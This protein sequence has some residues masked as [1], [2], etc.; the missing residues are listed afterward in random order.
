VTQCWGTLAALKPQQ[1]LEGPGLR[2]LLCSQDF[3]EWEA[4]LA[5]SLGHHRSRLLP[6][7]LPF[8]AQIRAGGVDEFQVLWLQGTG[9]LEL[10]REQCGHGVLWLP[11]QGLSHETINGEEQLS[12]PGMG[13]LFR[14][15]DV[16]RGLTTESLSGVSIVVPAQHLDGLVGAAPL[17]RQGP[18]ARQLIEAGWQLAA[19]AASQAVGASYAA[20]SLVDALQQWGQLLQGEL[21]RERISASQCRI[22]VAEACHWMDAHLAERFSVVALSQALHVSVRSLQYSFQTELG[23]TP[24]AEAKR[25]RLRRLRLLLQRA[26]LRERSIAELMGMAGL[27]ACGVTAADYRQWCGESPRRTRQRHRLT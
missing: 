15:G 3:G 9:Q 13:L 18:R 21:A 2:P 14:P 11:L 26:E 16:M 19:A 5:R 17:L 12:E 8:E 23:C 25:L 6:G 4:Q 10:Q 1:L 27:L 7:S 22:T 24:M 20:A